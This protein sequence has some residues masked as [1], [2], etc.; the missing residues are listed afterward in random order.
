MREFI[1]I[2][3]LIPLFA[4]GQINDGKNIIT[5]IG[6]ANTEIEPNWI[7]LSMTA[8]ETESTKKESEI[9]KM[10]NSFLGFIN[11][12][13]LDS[14]DFFIDR[15]SA[16]S[17]ISYSSTSKLKMN[18][19]Y[20]LK[21]ENI[22]LLDTI[23]IKCFDLGLDNIAINQ[24]GHSNIDSIQNSVLKTALKSARIKADLIAKEMEINLGKVVSVDETFK[25]INNQS[26]SIDFNDYQLD[27]IL[28]IG[29]GVQAKS[30]IGSS[31]NFQKIQ[32]SKT[33]I[34]KYEIK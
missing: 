13:G 22:K 11:S 6:T 5:V 1:L 10:E 12:L 14:N 28:S 20:G 21:I 27:N 2:I 32:V 23:I 9:V 29:Y 33:V 31:L 7:L 17:K 8:K 34:V 19:S 25:M 16:N 26:G 30:R 18:K 24:I 4:F 3:T 15:Y